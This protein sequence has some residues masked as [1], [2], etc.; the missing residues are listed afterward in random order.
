VCQIL[1]LSEIINIYKLAVCVRELKPLGFV[2]SSFFLLTI[3][4]FIFFLNEN[5][6][7][8]MTAWLQ[9]VEL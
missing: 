9:E 6:V 3:T 7:F 4:T 5:E 2:L 8:L 1:R